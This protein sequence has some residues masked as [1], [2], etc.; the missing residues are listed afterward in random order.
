MVE[1][2]LG[3]DQ[4]AGQ[5]VAALAGLLV[6][7]GSLQRMRPVRRAQALDCNDFLAGDGRKR[8]AARFLWFAVDQAHAAATL[9]EA[10]GEFG[11]PQ[12]EVIAQDVEQRRF[13]VRGRAD[14]I[15]IYD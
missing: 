8:L 14:G 11:P 2:S 3:G 1:Q 5:A 4:D 15:S 9:F 7:K 12:T 13:R 6:D 10:A